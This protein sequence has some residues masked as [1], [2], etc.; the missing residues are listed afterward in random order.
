MKIE[1]VPT[2]TVAELN[3][4]LKAFNLP[5]SGRKAD[6]VSRLQSA[7]S[8]ACMFRPEP[9]PAKKPRRLV[10]ADVQ[11][12]VNALKEANVSPQDVNSAMLKKIV[13][14]VNEKK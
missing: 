5:V 1:S 7:L 14:M 12:V 4:E 9:K 11:R 8:G 6:K 3:K 10:Q 13:K 2:L